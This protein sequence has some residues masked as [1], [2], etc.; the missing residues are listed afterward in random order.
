MNFMIQACI[1]FFESPYLL[2]IIELAS[3]LIRLSLF[4]FLAYK[5]LRLPKI[6]KPLM[7]LM[8]VLLGSIIHDLSWIIFL[9]YIN[10]KVTI[11]FVRIA[12]A[13]YSM[14]HQS[15]GLFIESLSE[16]D[17]KVKLHQIF[18]FIINLFCVSYFI[19]I[20]IFNYDQVLI[21]E[22][23]WL[24]FKMMEAIACFLLLFILPSLYLTLRKI[25]VANFPKILKKQ[26]ALLIKYLIIPYTIIEFGHT[27]YLMSKNHSYVFTSIA[28]FLLTCA[29]FFTLRKIMG[30]RFLNF[31]NHVQSSSIKF[32]FMNDFKGILE[33]LSYING[34]QE[35]SHVTQAFFKDFFTIM[36]SRVKLYFRKLQTS[37]TD[38]ETKELS[39]LEAIVEYYLAEKKYELLQEICREQK[40]FIYDDIA[41][42]NFYEN[43]EQHKIVLQ[44]LDAV[45][46]DVFLP[47][48]DRQGLIAYI[49]IERDA[50]LDKLYSDVE[51]DEMLVYASY[52][53]NIINLLQNR[54]L[55]QLIQKEKQLEETLYQKHQ[56]INQYKESIRTFLRDNKQRKIGILFY[57]GGRFSFGNK[58]AKDLV[59]VNVNSFAGHPLVKTLKQLV[60][61]VEEY[62]TNSTAYAHDAQGNKLVL[63]AIAGLEHNMTIIMVYYPEIADVI[64]RQSDYLQNPS[65]WD[66]LLYLETT[67][68]GQLINQLVPGS[69]QQLLNFKIELLKLALSK[70]A[71]LLNMPDDDLLATVEILHHISLRDQLHVLKLQAPVTDTSI[72]ITLFGIN[73]IFDAQQ[74]Q[75]PLL[76]KLNDIGTLFIQNIH[77]LDLESQHVLAEYIKYGFY[78]PYKSDKRISSN[79]RIICS[80]NQ[81]LQ[82]LVQDGKFSRPLFN[83]LKQVWLSM[84]SLQSLPEEEISQL[85]QGFSQQ[86]IST[87]LLQDFLGLSEKEKGK[88][89]QS[90]PASLQEFKEKVQNLLVQKSKKSNVY[91]ETYF[92]PSYSVTDPD[93][94]EAK[95][96]GKYALKNPQTLAM[97]LDKFQKNQ[98]KIAQFLGVNRSSVNRRCKDYNL[99]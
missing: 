52:L 69:G 2:F 76:E 17:Y 43:S 47:V 91:Q 36:P 85:A 5:A 48:F 86:A 41:F 25:Q 98:N 29:I 22:R 46:A 64:K 53:G 32:N 62:R 82:T 89:L 50:R 18:F 70:K 51:R 60:H 33:Q 95:K 44:F 35:L 8:G 78:H 9:S 81:N 26:L 65:E 83:E 27:F 58:D 99:L 28:T 45:Q 12:W 55:N 93:L 59:D 16:H 63:S 68:S 92:D 39:Q 94:M 79:V 77:Y 1:Q 13:F 61:H 24:E 84:P 3:L 30:M 31:Q 11:F 34:A 54:N 80:S 10:L 40:I 23:S 49:I 6:H 88:F 67:K 71:L 74:Q 37:R 75:Q 38:D 14:Q 97:L 90:R 57:K 19:F 21:E 73:P 72:A 42:S 87:P 56:E 96:L 20:S 7:F 15:L 66:Y 4:V